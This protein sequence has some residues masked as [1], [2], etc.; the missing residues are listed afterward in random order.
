MPP[1]VGRFQE[2]HRSADWSITLYVASSVPNAP[3]GA[4]R[5]DS[6]DLCTTQADYGDILYNGVLFATPLTVYATSPI[7]NDS[8]VRA[9]ANS[10]TV[11]GVDGQPRVKKKILYSS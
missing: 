9:G 6:A 3:E 8:T 1:H 7:R 4:L 2:C 5:T 11:P 10:T